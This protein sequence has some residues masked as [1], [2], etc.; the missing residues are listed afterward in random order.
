M[1]SAGKCGSM[2]RY[3]PPALNTADDR[4]HPVQ[5]ALG[6]HR[7][8]ALPA[9]APGQ[10]RP[11]DPVGTGVELAVGPLPVAVHR[12]DRV[13]VPPDPLLEQ[14]VE[15]AVRQLA[16]GPGEPLQLEPQLLGGQQALP[17][18]LGVGI[19]GDQRER[20]Q[21]VAGD[22]ARRTPRRARPSG[23][24]AAGPPDR[25]GRRS[26]PA[27]ALRPRRHR[28][29]RDRRRSRTTGRSR[30]A[31]AEDRRPGSR[32][33]AAAPTRPGASRARARATRRAPSSAGTAAAGDPAPAT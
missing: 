1:R 23:S 4:G 18:V 14:L 26:R 28:R 11:A 10:Q 24:A 25:H 9:Q 13:R 12:R 17:A 20:G 32:R 31:H 29:R 7:D 15:P 22:P 5:V 8:H 21:V 2:G 19:R 33:A 3:T 16:T 6:D 27:A 30:P